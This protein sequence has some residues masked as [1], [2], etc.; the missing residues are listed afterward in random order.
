MADSGWMR[1]A[2]RERMLARYQR[3]VRPADAKSKANVGIA[4]QW[5]QA[6]SNL[7]NY[8]SMGERYDGG[9]KFSNKRKLR[10]R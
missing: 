6:A 1:E 4:M 2:H 5:E 10:Q 8:S 3:R 7:S 9:P